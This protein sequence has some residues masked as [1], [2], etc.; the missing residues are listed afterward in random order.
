MVR[1]MIWSALCLVLLAVF[2]GQ[3]VRAP[4][5]RGSQ[6]QMGHHGTLPVLPL[7]CFPKVDSPDRPSWTNPKLDSLG[8][9]D[10]SSFPLLP[11][12]GRFCWLRAPG[13][14][15]GLAAKQNNPKPPPGRRTPMTTINSSTFVWTE[16]NNTSGEPTTH[17]TQPQAMGRSGPCGQ[18]PSRSPGLHTISEGL[19]RDS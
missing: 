16:S 3:G 9:A 18:A 6:L 12:G 7:R 10:G 14:V 15:G 19:N 2:A 13:G 1:E 17:R 8:G 4:A 5:A 11:D